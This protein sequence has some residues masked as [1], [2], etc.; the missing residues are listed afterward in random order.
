MCVHI[1]VCKHK[2]KGEGEDERKEI[3]S[4]VLTAI[5]P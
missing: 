1:Y 2:K 3:Y 4:N 5:I